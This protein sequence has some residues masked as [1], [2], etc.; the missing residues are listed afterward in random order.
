MGDWVDAVRYSG[1]MQYNADCF[2]RARVCV[3]GTVHSW[4]HRNH[5]LRSGVNVGC[6]RIPTLLAAN[7]CCDDVGS[8]VCSTTVVIRFSW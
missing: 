4:M 8:V 3:K 5:H 6:E 1:L 2:V 7:C